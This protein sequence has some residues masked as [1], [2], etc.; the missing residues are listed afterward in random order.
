MAYEL[1]TGILLPLVCL[2]YEGASADLFVSWYLPIVT[3]YFSVFFL[4]FDF[5][6]NFYAELSGFADR[7]FYQDFWNATNFDEYARKWNRP[8]HEYLH[9][10]WYLDILKTYHRITIFRATM[11][12]FLYS[13]YFHEL[14]LTVLFRETA[15]YLTS[16]QVYQLLLFFLPLK[17]TV[18]GNLV[19]WTGQVLCITQVLYLYAYDLANFTFAPR[20]ICPYQ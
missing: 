4:I 6:T 8:V 13:V 9:R 5:C 14:F 7:Q 2:F 16:L 12:T 19:F 1:A 10:H 20:G 17:G 11:V 3:L 15:F 18:I